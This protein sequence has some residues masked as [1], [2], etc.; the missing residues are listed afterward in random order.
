M[1]V[2]VIGASGT[3]GQAVVTALGERHEVIRA[4]RSGEVKVDL[5][6]PKSIRTMYDIVTNIDAIVCAAGTAAFGPLDQ[7][8]DD[9]FAFGLENK[10]M[11]QLNL[12]RYGRICLGDN[13][14]FTLTSGILAH[15]PGPA[16]A[17]ISVINAGIE[18]F[19][20]AAAIDMPRGQRV[21][22]V[23]PPLV[24]ETA[25][26]LGWGPGGIPAAEVA[27]FYVQA[28]EGDMNG[29]SIGPLH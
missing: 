3:I 2:V 13:A 12:V 22:A 21:N 11:G 29:R 9:D 24:K 23:C 27:E 16:T 25:E 8:A 14:S 18:V 26:K 6:D 28:L 5:S 1:K 17:L 15:Q 19:I 10:L 20:K 4:S 7:L